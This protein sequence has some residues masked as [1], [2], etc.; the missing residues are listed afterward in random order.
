[1]PPQRNGSALECLYAIIDNIIPE[2]L[3]LYLLY[4][5]RKRASLDNDARENQRQEGRIAQKQRRIGQSCTVFEASQA[6]I[7]AI[8]EGPDYVCVCCNRLM[9]R[10]TVQQ[11]KEFSY[12]KAPSEFVIPKSA[13][14]Q[15]KQWICKTCHSGLKRGV[16]PAQAKANN[17]NLDDIPMELY[18]RSESTGDTSHFSSNPLHENGSTSLWQATCDSWASCQCTH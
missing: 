12:D 8:K 4:I 11:F 2:L 18:I 17:L 13:S 10:K 7:S 14:T 5:Y 16:L 15:D 3:I 6:F 1:M 9:Y